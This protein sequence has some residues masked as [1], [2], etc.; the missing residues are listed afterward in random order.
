[1]YIEALKEYTIVFCMS[2]VNV[3]EQEENP[4]SKSPVEKSLNEQTG[5]WKNTFPYALTKSIK[6][7][8]ELT[9]RRKRSRGQIPS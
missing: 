8:N 6:F 7:S 2:P 5:K 4:N 1:M 9:K 3:F